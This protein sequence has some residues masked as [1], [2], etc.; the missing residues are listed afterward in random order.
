MQTITAGAPGWGGGCQRAGW[1]CQ[2]KGEKKKEK[3]NYRAAQEQITRK[4][5]SK[6]MC[7]EDVRVCNFYNEPSNGRGP[8]H[9]FFMALQTKVLIE[10]LAAAEEGSVTCQRS[11]N[12]LMPDQNGKAPFSALSTSLLYSF[13]F[14]IQPIQG[15]GKSASRAESP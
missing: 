14:H 1:H 2:E 7:Q 15:I 10:C 11:R 12:Y 13:P 6:S 3:T 9:M 5:R 8:C 4:S